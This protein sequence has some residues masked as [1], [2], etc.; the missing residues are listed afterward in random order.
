[1]KSEPTPLPI[2]IPARYAAILGVDYSY[3]YR[4]NKGE[5]HLS[6]PLCC[7]LMGWAKKD[8]DLAGL[9]LS[10]LRPDLVEIHSLWCEEPH[11][12]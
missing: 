9:S 4:V 5:R 11:G 12:K 1:M 8:P 6:P 3:I 10:H 2:P 7:L